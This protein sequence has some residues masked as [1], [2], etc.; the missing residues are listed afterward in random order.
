MIC[1]SKL[2]ILKGSAGTFR[3]QF[4]ILAIGLAAAL[5]RPR[6]FAIS[7]MTFSSGRIAFQPPSNSA[8]LRLALRPIPGTSACPARDRADKVIDLAFEVGNPPDVGLGLPNNYVN[9]FRHWRF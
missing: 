7:G 4:Q 2:R 5:I 1:G 3:V 9:A 6:A 8:R